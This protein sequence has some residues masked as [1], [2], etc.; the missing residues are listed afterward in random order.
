MDWAELPTHGAL[1]HGL[2]AYRDIPAGVALAHAAAASGGG[3]VEVT[4]GPVAEL[5]GRALAALLPSGE[6]AELDPAGPGLGEP[7]SELVLV[8]VHPQ[9]GEVRQLSGGAVAVP[10]EA[11]LSRIRPCPTSG[12]GAP[13]WPGAPSTSSGHDPLGGISWAMLNSATFLLS[14]MPPPHCR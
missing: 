10:V 9:T 3:P 1:W 4:P 11:A 12:L 5:L 6:D 13:G 8:P 7:A 14:P 2:S